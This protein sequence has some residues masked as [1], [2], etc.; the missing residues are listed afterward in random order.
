MNKCEI[1]SIAEEHVHL[2]DKCVSHNTW[3]TQNNRTADRSSR[4]VFGSRRCR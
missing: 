3:N 1:L 2:L 4:V